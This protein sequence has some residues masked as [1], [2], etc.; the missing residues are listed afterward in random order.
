MKIFRLL[1]ILILA[2]TLCIGMIAC[3]DGDESSSSEQ[4]SSSKVE[5]SSTKEEQSVSSS[6]KNEDNI[7]SNEWQSTASAEVKAKAQELLA[8]KHTLKYNEDGSFRVMIIADAHMNAQSGE[9]E[10]IQ[11]VKDRVKLLVDK[12]DP[13]LVILTGDNIINASTNEKAIASIEAIVGYIEEKQIPWCHVYGNHDHEGA[14]GK[15]LQQQVY[16]SF[17]YCVSK[18][19]P[20]ELSGVGNYVLGVYKNDGS[21]GSV[22][23]CIDSGTYDNTKGG[24]AYIKDD[25]IAWYKESSELLQEYNDGEKV[26]GIMAF[27]IPLIENVEASQNA[28]NPEI[29]YEFTG[30]VNENMC[31]S[32]TDTAL[33]ETI[34]ERGD[35]SAIVTG[36]DHINDYMFNYKGVKLSSSPNISDLTYGNAE[37]QGSRVFDLNAETMSNV[38]TYVEYIKERYSAEGQDTFDSVLL[39]DGEDEVDA[40]TSGYN[41]EGLVGSVTVGVAEGAGADGSRAISISRSAAN[42]TF[43]VSFYFDKMGKLGKNKYLVVWADLT[44]VDFRK[45]CF[46]LLSSEGREKSYR[47][48]DDDTSPPL[49][50]LADGSTDWQKLSHGWDG[51]FGTAQSSSVV[52]K[53][54]YFAVC[55]EDLLQGSRQMNGETL[56]SGFYFYGDLSESSY[57]NKP[58]YID[59]IMLVEDYKAEF[60]INS[61]SK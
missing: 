38:P 10:K 3:D 5:E 25:Q 22:I 16:E 40:L 18:A 43:E 49:Y 44:N 35:I 54:G 13:N 9:T 51:C 34:F 48:D 57:A 1:T 37:V 15:F 39:E 21:L 26:K 28:S 47:A 55:V 17:E 20:E 14:M 41:L 30:S 24:Y 19:G 60:P 42:A 11:A 4:S 7:P 8:T 59:N 53:K 32:K 23:Y 58:F 46:G 12:I 45:A 36:H 31:P 29:V 33:L 52:G 2:L 50:Y 56:V 27:H 61:S 6:D